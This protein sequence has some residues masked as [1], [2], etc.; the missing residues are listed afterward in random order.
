M[1]HSGTIRFHHGLAE[2]I[3]GKGRPPS[4][5]QDIIRSHILRFGLFIYP[6]P[7]SERAVKAR[8]NPL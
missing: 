3:L 2:D 4:P 7:E 5:P 1:A 6:L 8:L